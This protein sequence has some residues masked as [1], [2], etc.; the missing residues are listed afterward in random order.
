[1]E[2]MDR[3]EVQNYPCLCSYG[4]SLQPFNGTTKED[5]CAQSLY[6]IK[7]YDSNDCIVI[8]YSLYISF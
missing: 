7:V 8:I 6:N 5:D 2:Y 3:M 1:M 4:T